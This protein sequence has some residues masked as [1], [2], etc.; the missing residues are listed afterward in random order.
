MSIRIIKTVLVAF[1]AA[2]FFFTSPSDSMAQDCRWDGT[3]PYCAG[4]CGPGES[5]EF[6]SDA[7]HKVQHLPSKNFFGNGC[8]FGTKAYCCKTP[9][10]TCRWDGT[11]PFC[12]G[13]CRDDEEEIQRCGSCS[14]KVCWTGTKA[15]CCK[16]HTG[17]SGSPLNVAYNVEDARYAAIW[18]K[19]TATTPWVARHG[20]T[21][22]QFQSEFNKYTGQG[23]RLTL[24]NGYGVGNKDY[25]VAIW[26]KKSGPAWVARHGMTSAQYQEAFNT[27]TGLGYKLT[28]ISG[29][30]VGNTDYYA[31]IWEKPA[32][33][34][35]WVARHALTSDQYQQAFNTYV[36]QGYRLTHVSGYGVGGQPRYAAIW[37]KKS[38]PA[39]AAR[40]GMT[41]DQYQQEFNQFGQ[42][43]YRLVDVS[44]Y[45]DSTGGQALFAA[46]WEKKSG[47]AWAARHGMTSSGY[48]EEFNTHVQN[49]FRLL[50]VSGYYTN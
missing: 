5:E 17:S 36:G 28:H 15:K 18:Q 41:S 40:H 14:G 1:M 31:A 9:G 13:D 33:S 4:E 45:S 19:S 2:G 7:A 21:S 24:V 50:T 38:G 6:R 25:Y 37:E 48:Q 32:N 42:Q 49:G 20:M 43:G 27:Y 8:V 29:Y 12:A 10:R 46:I 16:E 22:S 3:A 44:A 30:G 35:P 39:W 47:P 34:A 26:E 23:F 11:A